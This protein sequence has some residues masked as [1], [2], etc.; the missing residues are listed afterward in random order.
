M[1]ATDQWKLVCKTKNAAGQNWWGPM[2]SPFNKKF[3]LPTN[4]PGDST[5]VQDVS[6]K[7]TLARDQLICRN[8]QRATALRTQPP[9][10]PQ[11]LD[12]DS[13]TGGL[14]IADDTEQSAMS[15]RKIPLAS[16]TGDLPLSRRSPPPS[17]TRSR[18]SAGI[19]S[20]HRSR[21]NQS[22]SRRHDVSL[23]P[24]KDRMTCRFIQPL[25][26]T[27]PFE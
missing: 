12:Y 9:K 14:Y 19:H 21:R 25:S 13:I 23:C 18:S 11:L 8:Q 24:P 17:S 22:R 10:F 6:W 4:D 20:G 15:D 2:G 3:T 5:W 7:G 27:S 26:S 1:L 16:L